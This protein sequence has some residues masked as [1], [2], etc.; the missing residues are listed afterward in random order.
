MFV[1]QLTGMSG[2]GKTTIAT[3]VKSRFTGEEISLE[4]LD[5]DVYRK[6]LCKDLGFSKEDRCENIRRLGAAAY[7]FARQK[8]IAIIAA[9]NPFETIRD[10]LKLKYGAKLVWIDCDL[11]TVIK[12]DT[13]GLY[14]RALLQGNEEGKI[15]NLSGVNDTYDIPQN[16]DLIIRTHLESVEESINKLYR[17][18]VNYL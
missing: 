14:K 3:G 16:P 6:T 9:I 17:F 5:G 4:V 10:E 8:R 2:A 12:R 13:K 1:I 15:Y 18:I 7:S 11:H